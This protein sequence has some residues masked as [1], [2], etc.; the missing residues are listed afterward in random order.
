MI[1]MAS[2]L[3]FGAR[4]SVHITQ[5]EVCMKKAGLLALLVGCL[6]LFVASQ[7]MAGDYTL[8]VVNNI[9][10]TNNNYGSPCNSVKLDYWVGGTGQRAVLSGE[11][12]S[13]QTGQLKVYSAGVCSSME[14]YAACHYFKDGFM[15]STWVDEEKTQSISCGC[16]QAQIGLKETNY[17]INTVQE[18]NITCISQ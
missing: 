3:L 10:K 12:A 16:K 11:L 4:K 9:H 17:G 14:L 5:E 18:L 1:A 13:G 2:A 15:S 8:S 6:L 7:A